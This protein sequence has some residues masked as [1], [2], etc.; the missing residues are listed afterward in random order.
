MTITRSF[1]EDIPNIAI[2]IPFAGYLLI[3]TLY[4][5][6]LNINP[7]YNFKIFGDIGI[8]YLDNENFI[9]SKLI[10]ACTISRLGTAEQKIIIDAE[11]IIG[12]I[13]IQNSQRSE[14]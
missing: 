5:H 14:T 3:N 1:Q 4:K 2:N 7:N 12:K 13:Q 6:I 9:T 8:A 10:D 11:Q